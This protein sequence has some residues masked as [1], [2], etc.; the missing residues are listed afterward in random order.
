MFYKKCWSYK[1][2]NIHRKTTVLDSLFNN[3]IEKRLQHMRFPVHIANFYVFWNLRTAASDYP[4]TLVM[5]LKKIYFMKNIYDLL[6]WKT[7]SLK[8]DYVIQWDL[9]GHVKIVEIYMRKFNVSILNRLKIVGFFV[10]AFQ[11]SNAKC[12][13]K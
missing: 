12:H 5:Y 8:L 11:I 13:F 2:C 6:W 9:K 3:V 10:N 4:V 7:C 1:F